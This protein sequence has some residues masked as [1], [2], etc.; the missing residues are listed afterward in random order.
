[1]KLTMIGGGGVRSPLVVAS[2]LRR[3]ERIHLD[4]ICLMDTDEERLDLIGGLCHELVR[5]SERPVRLTVTSDQNEA[6][7][8]ARHVIMTI[9]VGSQQGRARD[10]RICQDLGVLGQE[11]TGAGGFAMAM[12]SVPM[13]LE[14][15]RAIQQASTGAWLYNFTNPAGLVTQALRDAGFTQAI[16]ICDGANTAQHEIARWLGVPASP[17]RPEVFGLNHLSWTRKVLL[18]GKDVLAPM[19]ADSRFLSQSMLQIFDPALVRRIGMWLNEYLYYFYYAE[20]AVERMRA[21][22]KTRGEEILEYD[23][24]LIEGLQAAGGDVERAFTVYSAYLEQRSG[25]YMDY[26]GLVRGETQPGGPGGSAFWKAL[27]SSPGEEEESY[28]GVALNVIEA[29]ENGGPA[30]I[31][32]NVPNGGAIQ[33]MHPEDVVEVSCVVRDGAVQPLPIGEI[34]EAQHLLMQAVKAYER[35]AVSAIRERSREA[36]VEALMAHPLILSYSRS[37]ALVEAFL[38]AHRSYVGNWA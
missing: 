34:P 10:E 7:R 8:D 2:A 21:K 33:G 13:V 35:L 9:R 19:L 25:T 36:A 22:G 38:E 23:S 24:R 14:Y 5:I 29:L 20:R 15:A 11:T 31:A 18:D 1:M 16:G 12:R 30:T 6:V 26:A 17:L 4:E 3:A 37:T 28:A 27:L 32:L